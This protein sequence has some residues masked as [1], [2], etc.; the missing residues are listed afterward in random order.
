MIC[1]FTKYIYIFILCIIYIIFIKQ[2]C[3]EFVFAH[4]VELKL[5]YIGDNLHAIVRACGLSNVTKTEE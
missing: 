3:S 5:R 4:R 1:L 2:L